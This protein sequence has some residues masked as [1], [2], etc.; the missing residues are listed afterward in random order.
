MRG[1]TSRY[2]FRES[3]QSGLTDLTWQGINLLEVEL[4]LTQKK[5]EDEA[6][7]RLFSVAEEADQDTE[8]GGSSVVSGEGM[9]K[10]VEL[11]EEVV[12]EDRVNEADTSTI[13]LEKEKGR[14][15]VCPAPIKE[16]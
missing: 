11:T 1:G 8:R 6:A 9:E 12:H 16:L 5:A 3:S 7:F 14:E 2:A 15:G 10:T 13:T 4:E